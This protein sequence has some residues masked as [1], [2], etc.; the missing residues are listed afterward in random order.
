MF[1]THNAQTAAAVHRLARGAFGGARDADGRFRYEFQKLHGMGDD[2]YAEVIPAD[3]LDVPCRVYAPV[4]SHE[5]L[6]PYLVRRLLENGANSSFVNR[7]TD[8]DVAIDDL[9]RDPVETVD[10]FDAIPHPRRSEEHTSELP[11][12]MPISYAVFCLKK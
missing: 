3:R 2:L 8:E 9:V 5:D 1:A 11:S 6:L 10:A 12:L 7:I 4:G